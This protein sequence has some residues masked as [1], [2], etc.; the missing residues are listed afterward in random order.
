MHW[1]EVRVYEKNVISKTKLPNIIS[2]VNT[3]DL[4]VCSK[5]C[6]ILMSILIDA[7]GKVPWHGF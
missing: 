3:I 2:Y 4:K 1:I 5:S 6:K 7:M